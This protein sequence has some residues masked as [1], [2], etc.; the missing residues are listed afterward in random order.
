[1]I[2]EKIE[3]AMILR[4]ACKTFR[5]IVKPTTL[6]IGGQRYRS[7]P[8]M[9]MFPLL[10]KIVPRDEFREDEITLIMR[11]HHRPKGQ[12]RTIFWGSALEA[13]LDIENS[14]RPFA[15]GM[16]V[17]S[18]DNLLKM[19][20]LSVKSFNYLIQD[21]IPETVFSGSKS[22]E[23]KCSGSESLEL[24]CSG[25]K[26]LELK[27]SGSR[28]SI[29]G[30]IVSRVLK[31]IKAGK[32]NSLR[33]N[34]FAIA[35]GNKIPEFKRMEVLHQT[36][37]SSSTERLSCIFSFDR[38]T[39][40]T[41][42][43]ENLLFK[44][45]TKHVTWTSKMQDP[46]GSILGDI[47]P[48]LPYVS[49]V[50]LGLFFNHTDIITDPNMENLHTLRCSLRD[51]KD[52]G[53]YWFPKFLKNCRLHHLSQVSQDQGNLSHL[54]QVS[55]GQSNL[56]QVSQGQG[57]FSQSLK[58]TK[59][60]K[61]EIYIFNVQGGCDYYETIRNLAFF[62][63]IDYT[64]IIVMMM[65]NVSYID[66]LSSFNNVLNLIIN[67]SH[68]SNFHLI[69]GKADVPVRDKLDSSVEGPPHISVI[70]DKHFHEMYS[71]WGEKTS[72]FYTKH[73]KITSVCREYI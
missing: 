56:S 15:E 53:D 60:M 5:D 4:R 13:Y 14:Y 31:M 58:D 69:K 22:L 51:Y 17:G 57:N 10:K 67:A 68:S 45:Q 26:S 19:L 40:Y 48:L 36:I 29:L 37:F 6:K 42:F 49:R 63:D 61:I 28:S 46:R 55:Q 41:D 8:I 70:T 9:K 44:M 32:L 7:L 12:S 18:S 1:M 52:L 34:I 39:L 20:D 72:Y 23:L 43:D 65:Y 50:N 62:P 16:L 38:G 35:D 30:A 54:S 21:G 25:S 64:F 47:M 3:T 71:M 59:R 11:E 73:H 24:K 33:I 66:Q 27:C 2:W